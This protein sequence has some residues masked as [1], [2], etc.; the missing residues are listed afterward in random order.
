MSIHTIFLQQQISKIEREIVKSP[1]E[2]A[3]VIDEDGNYVIPPKM[4][5]ID[6]IDFT[7]E[8]K[9][10]FTGCIFMHNHPLAGEFI[11]GRY[12]V[13]YSFSDS[14]LLLAFCRELKELRAVDKKYIYSLSYQT[15]NIPSNL[16]CKFVS[17]PL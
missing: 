11:E 7:E 13:D 8:E 3:H 15:G 10:H 16:Y 5:K 12:T 6:R 4:G 9:A 14:D 17:K 1:I 2:I